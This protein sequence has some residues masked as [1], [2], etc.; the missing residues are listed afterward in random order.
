M[1]L[2]EVLAAFRPAFGGVTWKRAIPGILADP[3]S[4][5]V[6]ELLRAE[7]VLHG[8]FAEPILVDPGAR[9]ILDGMHR[10]A[11]AVLT[12]HDALDLT[13][14]EADLPE[15]RLVLATLGVAAMS[16]GAVDRLARALR[17]FPLAGG[18]TTCGMLFPGDD[19]VSGWWRCP[20]GQDT[21][22]GAELVVRATRAGVPVSLISITGVDEPDEPE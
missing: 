17:S 6:V 8:G 22:L 16:S 13:D 1:P 7:L 3:D 15:K 2:T 5:Q 14:T 11:A 20:P 12:E 10:I 4:A 19:Q 21:T 18:W 9:E